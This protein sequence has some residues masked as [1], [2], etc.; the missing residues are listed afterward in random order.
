MTTYK[1]V[2]EYFEKNFNYNEIT[3]KNKDKKAR[4][5]L[6][7]YEL[8]HYEYHSEFNKLVLNNL[9]Y[10]MFIPCIEEEYADR[11]IS[12]ISALYW[13]EY[14]SSIKGLNKAVKSLIDD[15]TVNKIKS[16]KE[17]KGIG[18]EM[19][20]IYYFHLDNFACPFSILDFE[21]GMSIYGKNEAFEAKLKDPFYSYPEQTT[22]RFISSLFEL[23]TVAVVKMFNDN[24]FDYYEYMEDREE[25]R[26]YY[27][28]FFIKEVLKSEKDDSE[29]LEKLEG[30]R[31]KLINI[32]LEKEVLNSC[33]VKKNSDA[34]VK[35][36]EM[37]SELSRRRSMLPSKYRDIERIDAAIKEILK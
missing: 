28:E 9:N 8:N 29:K 30:Y 15:L 6:D 16:L 23:K 20:E 25:F 26:I 12:P 2:Q 14:N 17:I 3:D 4:E 7:S 34:S 5:T 36:K 32:K 27:E 11:L 10:E 35:L 22:L 37:Q 33:K 1:T 18:L 21:Y 24:V 31:R 13:N 19:I